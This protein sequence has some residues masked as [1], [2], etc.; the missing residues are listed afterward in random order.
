MALVRFPEGKLV[1]PI[2]LLHDPIGK[3]ESLEHL[4]CAASDAVGL[5]DYESAG[6]LLDDADGDIGERSELR[7]EG[8]TG[9]T[10]TDDK[11][12][13]LRWKF[14]RG[15]GRLML[16]VGFGDMRIARSEPVKVELHGASVPV[17]EK[18]GATQPIAQSGPMPDQSF[19]PGK[20]KG[21]T[22]L[23]GCSIPAA[24]VC[25]RGNLHP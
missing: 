5:A 8:Q 20:G 22:Q 11:D 17:A 4:H 9:G 19:S 24:K 13:D 23:P 16:G 12:V 3:A 25:L 18:I 15:A 21:S 14:V 7:G 1:D 6:F 2:S 10:A